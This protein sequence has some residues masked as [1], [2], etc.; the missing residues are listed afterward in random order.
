M[1]SVSQTSLLNCTLLG[2]KIIAAIA[3][4]ILVKIQAAD[5]LWM[6]ILLNFTPSLKRWG[7]LSLGPQ[8]QVVQ[9]GWEKTTRFKLIT[10]GQIMVKSYQVLLVCR[11]SLGC[12]M[13]C[14]KNLLLLIPHRS[15]YFWK[16]WNQCLDWLL[17]RQMPAD[18]ACGPLKTQHVMAHHGYR[19]SLWTQSLSFYPICM[20]FYWVY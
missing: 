4:A 20:F 10:F 15:L 17:C 13:V 12:R 8:L 18:V 19:N 6:L 1:L 5:R 7:S 11:R 14:L 16:I 9:C 2:W 3:F